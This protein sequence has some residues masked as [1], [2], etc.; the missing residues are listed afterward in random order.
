MSGVASGADVAGYATERDAMHDK[1]RKIR[2]GLLGC[3]AALAVAVI[4]AAAYAC[5]PQA[6]LNLSPKAGAPGTKITVTGSSFDATGGP[7]KLWWGGPG[8]SLIGEFPVTPGR[9]FTATFEVPADSAGGSYV[10]SATQSDANGQSI[11]GSPVSALFN[12]TG[13]PAPSPAPANP[14]VEP[15]QTVNE[16][17]SAVAPAA[18][19]AAAPAPTPVPAPR[20]RV[21]PAA[22]ASRTPAAA[23]AAAPAP[24]VAPAPV[25]VAPAAEP[26][27]APAAVAPLA[28]AGGDAPATTPARRSVMVS[29]SSDSDGSPALA[30][31]LVGVGLVLALGASAVVLAG[32]RE[33]KA[34]AARRR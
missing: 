25:P 29:M 27:P 28:P 26:T 11:A 19:Q 22:P 23:S 14:Q 18:T 10:V 1:S 21:A 30:I 24:A 32:R 9:S 16:P 4:G 17:A 3:A 15:E 33:R 5:V 20:V 12:V 7:A 2:G 34:P 6:S 8:K 13:V 31:A